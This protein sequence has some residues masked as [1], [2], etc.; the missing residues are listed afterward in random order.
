VGI[1]EPMMRRW[2]A[3]TLFAAILALGSAP[4]SAECTPGGFFCSPS[5]AVVR[6]YL[7]GRYPTI[8]IDKLEFSSSR[9]GSP[10]DVS[11][12]FRVEFAGTAMLEDDLYRDI[13]AT[14]IAK[15]CGA[16]EG[17]LPQ[18]PQSVYRLSTAKGTAIRFSGDT[19]MRGEDGKW[20][21][22]ADLMNYATESGESLF[23][24]TAK[25]LGPEAAILGLPSGDAYCAVL[26]SSN[27]G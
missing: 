13:P 11:Q 22:S 4:A 23:G 25:D 14:E 2:L 24:N 9:F 19:A 7:D 18:S 8:I 12:R 3:A 20:I 26:R 1:E 27:P 15:A 10:G 5:E 17:V 16:K 6:A 21:G